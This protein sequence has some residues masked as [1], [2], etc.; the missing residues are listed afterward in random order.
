MKPVKWFFYMNYIW[1]ESMENKEDGRNGNE[2]E[3]MEWVALEDTYFADL[4]A[5]VSIS[6]LLFVLKE[7]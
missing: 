2:I 1:K 5:N 3:R 7:H 6:I 4:Y